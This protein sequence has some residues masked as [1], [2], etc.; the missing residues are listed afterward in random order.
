MT[1]LVST[2]PSRNFEIIAEVEVTTASDVHATVAKA[3]S[4]QVKWAAL[5]VND[6]CEILKSFIKISEERTEEIAKLIALETGRPVNNSRG[7][8]SGGINFFNSYIEI[9]E[10]ALKPQLTLETK[11]EIHTVYREPW[12]VIGCICPWNYPFMNVVWQCGQAL[13]AG[14]AIVYKN[15]EENP[16]FARMMAEIVAESEIPEG[17]FNVIYGDGHTGDTLAH[18]D[19]DMLSFTGS[20]KTGHALASVAAEKF[21]PFVA[22]LGG[23]SPCIILEDMPITTKVIDYL[24]DLRFRHSG[25]FCNA[26]K[27]LIV[28]ESKFDELVEKLTKTVT[29]KKIG[30]ASEEDTDLGP[31]VAKRQ[32]DVIEVQVADAVNKGAKV[33]CGGKKPSGLQGAYYEP[34]ILTNINF[35]MRVWRE[36]TFG[37]VLPIVSF[38]R[39]DEAI[40]LANDTEYGLSAHVMTPDSERFLSIARQIHAG[41]VAQNIVPPFQPQNPFGGY[42]KSGLGRIHG[43]FGFD[44]V[45]QMKLVASEK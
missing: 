17:V 43:Q 15:S 19:I 32:V 30:D 38:K 8:V 4:A 20:S 31:L 40:K 45:T 14:N 37:P 25:Q 2:N 1:K 13:I 28:H 33:I 12:G 7:N 6:R 11:T 36:E 18:A 23:S 3:K 26:I 9:A 44:E 41:T 39:E 29:S 22:E 34:T 35:D 16:L 10:S 42:K 24:Y 5:S 27:R 21:I